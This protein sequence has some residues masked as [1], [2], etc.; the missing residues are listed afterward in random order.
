MAEST[1][2]DST[3]DD[4]DEKPPPK[5]DSAELKAEVKKWKALARQN[6]K[7]A[8]ANAEAAEKLVELEAGKSP[9]A[10]KL[11]QDNERLQ[12]ELAKSKLEAIRMKVAME[13]GLT[14]AQ[15]KRLVG[16]TEEEMSED[17]DELLET[18]KP[19][20]PAKDDEGDESADDDTDETETE[21]PQSRRP[22]K[23][24]MRPGLRPNQRVETTDIDKLGAEIYGGG[25]VKVS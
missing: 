19:A 22:P 5:D 15:A 1:T 16:D 7:A 11:R 14:P 10:E 13:K 6:E 3:D 12:G 24:K 18:F 9:D 20:K 21:E 4:T 23:E 17:A 2:D 25:E 8:K